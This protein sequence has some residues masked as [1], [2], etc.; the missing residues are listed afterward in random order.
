MA[1][2]EKLMEVLCLIVWRVLQ[3]SSG[4]VGGNVGGHYRSLLVTVGG[5]RLEEVMSEL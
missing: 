1:I 2:Y 4:V 5:R 3:E